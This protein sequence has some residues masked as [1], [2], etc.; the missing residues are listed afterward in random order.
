MYYIQFLWAHNR[1][2]WYICLFI[3]VC[4]LFIYTI[5][6]STLCISTEGLCLSESNSQVRDFCKWVFLKNKDILDLWK[7]FLVLVSYSFSVKCSDSSRWVHNWW[8][9]YISLCVCLHVFCSFTLFSSVFFV[10]HRKDI[11]L[12]NLIRRYVNSVSE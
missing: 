12:V 6:I 3:C 8:F 9:S 10:F 4:V 1:W 2:F 5:F 7:R 11:V